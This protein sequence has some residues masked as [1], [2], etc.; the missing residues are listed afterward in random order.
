MHKFFH[1][2]GRPASRAL[3][4]PVFARDLVEVKKKKNVL[5]LKGVKS[6]WLLIK[7]IYIRIKG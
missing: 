3:L 4:K 2:I 6:N 7:K 5:S 1:L